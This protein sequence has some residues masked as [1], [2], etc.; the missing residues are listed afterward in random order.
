MHVKKGA[1]FLVCLVNGS[2]SINM[3]VGEL[4]CFLASHKTAAKQF[5][6]EFFYLMHG[7]VF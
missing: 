5:L 4:A 6:L 2:R 1:Q 7:L 3:L